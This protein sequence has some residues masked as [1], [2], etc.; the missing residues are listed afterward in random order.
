MPLEMEYET[1]LEDLLSLV[2]LCN[3]VLE[4]LVSF[5]TERNNGLTVSKPSYEVSLSIFTG[6][7]RDPRVGPAYL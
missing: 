6:L 4:K 5:L 2:D 7:V 1:N 3:L